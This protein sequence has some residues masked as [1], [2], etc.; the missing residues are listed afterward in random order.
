L[1]ETEHRRM[2]KFEARRTSSAHVVAPVTVQSSILHTDD[3][4]LQ[5]S[6]AA[7]TPLAPPYTSAAAAAAA[8][9]PPTSTHGPSNPVLSN[10]QL[11][12]T[13]EAAATAGTVDDAEN[14]EVVD[15][16]DEDDDE[17]ED[18]EDTAPKGTSSW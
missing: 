17:D 2:A 16:L 14:T 5:S 15:K 7:T 8:A 18:E 6:V 10:T 9:R 11:F 3:G 1:S 13:T 12:N 4:W